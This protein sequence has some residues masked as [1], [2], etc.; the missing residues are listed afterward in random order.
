[1]KIFRFPKLKSRFLLVIPLI[2]GILLI[3][4]EVLLVRAAESP[5]GGSPTSSSDSRLKRLAVALEALSYGDP[6]DTVL[7]EN[8]GDYWN[9][10]GSA[11][12]A[13]FNDALVSG[14]RNGGNTDFPQS[15]GGIHDNNP[16][17]SG[18]YYS[19]WVTCNS[20]N[21]YCGTADATVET[22]HL[23]K[24]DPNTGLI[25]SKRVSAAANWFTANNC[26]QPSN[27]IAPLGPTACL[28]HNDAGCICTKLTDPNKTGCEA[29]GAGWRLPDQKELMMAYID[30]SSQYLN[31]SAASH[32][33]GTTYTSVTQNAW[34][35]TLSTGTTLT[36][37]KITSSY[38]F[39]CVR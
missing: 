36:N 39:R 13:P 32:W 11:A 12:Q 27:G 8:W 31:D 38:S 2:V 23:A 34:Y 26:V 35:T 33:S 29:L 18:S 4:R 5:P 9:R 19:D 1:M 22:T 15:K 17:P 24:Q 3:G 14:L 25:W 21:T 16:L 20:G 30:G 7:T 10:I 28:N 6:N 37:T